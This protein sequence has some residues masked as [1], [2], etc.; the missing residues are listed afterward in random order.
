M[1]TA[2]HRPG[3]EL[4]IVAVFYA[5]AVWLWRSTG[6]VFYLF[7]FVYIGT[8]VGLGMGLSRWLPPTRRQWAR[9]VTLLLVGL[10]MLGFLGLLQR[11][12]MQIEGFWLY[13]LSGMFAAAV[14]HYTI[15]KIAGPLLFGR[16]WCGWACWTAM[17]LDL[18]PYRRPLNARLAGFGGL[19]Y[20]H[21]LLSLIIVLFAWFAAGY[22]S[23]TSAGLAASELHWLIVGNSLYYV[24]GVTLAVVLKDNRAFCKYLCPI[25]TFL[26]ATSRFALLKI[27]GD[28]SRCTRCG[29]CEKACPMNIRIR[30]YIAAGTRV[31]STECIFCQ[32]CV[33]ACPAG[34][35]SISVGL[36]AGYR[37]LLHE[38]PRTTGP[39]SGARHE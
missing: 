18:L 1:K 37:E 24:S 35:L 22:R 2:T 38:R 7:N 36:D 14:L 4:I 17:V 26:K 33:E 8:A 27:R 16:A 19:R 25:T 20:A 32:S 12:N 31:T 30:D 6:H 21:F 29:L 9:R 11:E 34:A 10:Y 28:A 13:L 3:P 15:A 5:I 39:R 23:L